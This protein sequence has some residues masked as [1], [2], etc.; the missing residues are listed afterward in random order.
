MQQSNYQQCTG[1]ISS[2]YQL[3]K[4]FSQ[5]LI[6]LATLKMKN[7]KAERHNPERFGLNLI[8]QRA[9]QTRYLLPNEIKMSESLGI[10]KSEI[11]YWGC[12][13]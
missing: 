7:L 2:L 10:F 9:N 3:A 5:R 6:T 4:R 11:K 13:Y 8:P 1:K 12:Q